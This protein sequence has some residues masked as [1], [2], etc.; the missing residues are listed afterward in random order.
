MLRE[1]LVV[2]Q[3]T[4]PSDEDQKYSIL[5]SLADRKVVAVVDR[6]ADIEQAALALV[7]ARFGFNGR[8]AY[9]P[10]LVLVNEYVQKAFLEALARHAISYAADGVGDGITT[11]PT[12]H[13]RLLDEIDADS[14]IDVTARVKRGC[15][16]SIKTTYV[17]DDDTTFRG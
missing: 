2:E 7:D 5:G 16:V 4:S 9:A 12:G 17:V 6:T 3:G 15:I 14:S 11:S 1:V 13:K 8:S 10:D